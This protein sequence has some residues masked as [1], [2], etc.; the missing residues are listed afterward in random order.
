[1]DAFGTKHLEEWLEREFREE[2][3]RDDVRGLITNLW[4]SDEPY[5]LTKNHSYWDLLDIAKRGREAT[6]Q[7]YKRVVHAAGGVYVGVQQGVNEELVLFN[8]KATGDTLALTATELSVERIVAKI[9][10]SNAAHS[11]GAKR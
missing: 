4:N 11:K 1:M 9:Q 7:G 3:E 8:S 5:F 2:E 6:R 10:E